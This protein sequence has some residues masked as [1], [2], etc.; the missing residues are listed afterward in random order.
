VSDRNGLTHCDRSI[1]SVC[2]IVNPKFGGKDKVDE[3][4]EAKGRANRA[5]VSKIRHRSRMLA[6]KID[7]TEQLTKFSCEADRADLTRFLIRSRLLEADQKHD[8]E[9]VY[10]A[11]TKYF[12]R[13]LYRPAPVQKDRMGLSTTPVAARHRRLKARR[14]AGIRIYELE[15]PEIEVAEGLKRA[16]FLAADAESHDEIR[17]ALQRAVLLLFE[18]QT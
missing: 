17:D 7:P 4:R 3:R 10:A 8:P 5:G 15:L 16:G 9:A 18:D 14:K 1:V 13:V 2:R 11:L 12:N 6:P